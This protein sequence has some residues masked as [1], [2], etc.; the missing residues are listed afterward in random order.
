MKR[1]ILIT[2]VIAVINIMMAITVYGVPSRP[3]WR[4]VTLKD[5]RQTEAMLVGDEYG[6]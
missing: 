5:G 3:V 4:S 2:T 1:S 6:H